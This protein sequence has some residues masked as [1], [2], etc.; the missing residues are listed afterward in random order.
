MGIVKKHHDLL[1]NECHQL[2]IRVAK[3]LAKMPPSDVKLEGSYKEYVKKIRK[4]LSH[5]NKLASLELKRNELMGDRSD[6]DELTLA[7]GRRVLKIELKIDQA[8]GI[9]SIILL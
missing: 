3:E 2:D 7:D 1:V 4:L 6:I 8:V 9:T 5:Q